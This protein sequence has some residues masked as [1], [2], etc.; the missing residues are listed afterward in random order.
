MVIGFK[1]LV[2]FLRARHR[3][4]VRNGPVFFISKLSMSAI[5]VEL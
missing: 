2:P 1:S 5:H 4:R 3:D